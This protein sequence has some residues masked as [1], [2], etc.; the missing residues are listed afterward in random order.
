MGRPRFAETALLLLG[1]AGMAGCGDGGARPEGA[2]PNIL[3][4]VVDTLRAD[5]LGAYGRDAIET[6]EVDALASEG[7]LFERA[8]APSSWTRSSM[9]SLLTGVEPG[10]HGVMQRE[11]V[12][13]EGWSLLSERLSSQG[14]STGAIVTNPNIGSFFG[15][16]QGFDEFHE[17]YARREPGSVGSTEL[18][19][20]SDEVTRRA[21][22]WIDRHST[23]PFFLLLLTTDPHWPYLP[24]E[25]FDRYGGDYAGPVRDGGNWA[26]RTGLAPADR[27]RIR[28]FYYGEVAFNDA[29][30]GRLLGHLRESGLEDDTLVIF[31]ADHGEEFWEHGLRGHGKQLF[32]ESLRVPLILRWPALGRPGRRLAGPVAL[33]DVVPTVLDLLGL[34]V[35]DLVQG[36]SLVG[37]RDR[38]ASV[39]A[40]LDLGEESLSALVT[41]PWKLIRADGA[42]RSALFHLGSD[43]G[44]RRDLARVESDRVEALEAQLRQRIEHNARE[45]T[46]RG[47]ATSAPRLADDALPPEALEALEALGYL[48]ADAAPREP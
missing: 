3:L 33:V 5:A 18:V 12:L 47:E 13:T 39:H 24:P 20:R 6:P 11:D 16:D 36:R 15:F 27:E 48:E 9:A 21:I 45:R 29:S 43:P 2:R 8:Y 41:G 40:R 46:R 17:L 38:A 7:W 37:G 26:K 10:V 14:Y 31:T 30:F 28:S 19:T 35:S 44:E 1:L 42:R 34:P 32:E 23:G 22:E 4:Y 25:G